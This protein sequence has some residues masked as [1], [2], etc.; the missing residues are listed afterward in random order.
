MNV[1]II[2][3]GPA[4]IFAAIEAKKRF[5]NVTI[6]DLNSFVGRKLS[7]TGS[8]RCNIT[9]RNISPT[10]Y[11][12]TNNFSFDQLIHKYDYHF[13][14]SKLKELGIFTYQTEDGWVYPISNS[15]KNISQ[16]LED[17]LRSLGVNIYLNTNV[18]DISKVENQFSLITDRHGLLQ[19]DKIILAT[20]GN[21]YPQ[22]NSN[23]KILSCVEKLGH[24]INPTNPALA[25]LITTKKDTKNL[26]G[27]RLDATIRLLHQNKEI[28]KEFGNIIFTDWGI[29]GPGVMNLSHLIGKYKEEIKIII[30]FYELFPPD[31]FEQI[32]NKKNNFNSLAAPFYSIL[33]SKIITSVFK[34]CN[35]D[36]NDHFSEKNFFTVYN[37]LK[38]NEIVL[39]TRGFEFSQVSTGGIDSNYVNNLTLQSTL[40]TG[41]YFAGEVLDVI[42]PCGGFNLHWAFVSGLVAGKLLD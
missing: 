29:N 18:L 12:S 25:P 35:L 38:F 1:A 6:F 2:G 8:G 5:T 23:N 37:N 24:K 34:K 9:N 33:N 19:F 13:L 3:G 21:A 4:G 39:G 42:G 14:I 32:L 36:Q 20:G 11:H 40:C 17:H 16:L 22:L 31:Y 30:D 28:G 7:V 27:V 26:S 10:A 41:L 15:A